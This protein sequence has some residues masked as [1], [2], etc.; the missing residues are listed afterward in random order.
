[1]VDD[2]SA[3]GAN[4][5]A[6]SNA[7]DK[8]DEKVAF[9][10]YSKLLSEKK[11]RDAEIADYKSK[12]EAIEQQALQ[13]QGKYKELNETLKKQVAE[14]D[15]RIKTMFQEFG[16]KT[17]KTRFEAE[18]KNLGCVDPDALYKLVDL[19][20]VEINDDFSFNPDQLKNVLSESQK[21]RA[22]LFKKDVVNAKDASPSGGNNSNAGFDVSKLN[23][24]DLQKLLA[25]KLAKT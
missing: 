21:S 17:L 23:G 7:D 11:K 9:A 25:L 10:T 4:G 24:K 3:S 20:Q 2:T 1:M 8:K 14:K 12:L 15:T 19:E 13:D 22:Y 6:G 5:E 18:A 16:T